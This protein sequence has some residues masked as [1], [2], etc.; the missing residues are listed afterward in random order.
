MIQNLLKKLLGDKSE[1]DIK[2]IKPF[3]EKI[4]AAEAA[5]KGITAQGLRDKTADFKL[6]LKEGGKPEQGIID[7]LKQ[8]I[9][10]TENF[11]EKDNLYKQLEQAE[12]D[13]L[14]KEESILTDILPELNRQKKIYLTRKSPSLLTFYQRPL[15]SSVKQPSNGPMAIWWLRP[16]CWIEALLPHW[17][18]SAFQMTQRKPQLGTKHG[19]QQALT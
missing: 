14:D 9:E 15:R 1:R 4:H 11:A 19:Q 10:L 17:M 7:D 5:I 2:E 16:R 3:I 18:Q 8:Q 6:R 13:L 12:K